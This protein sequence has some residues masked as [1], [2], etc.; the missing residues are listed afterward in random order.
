MKFN[1]QI[2]HEQPHAFAVALDQQSRGF[3]LARVGVTDR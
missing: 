3:V 1:R 2:G